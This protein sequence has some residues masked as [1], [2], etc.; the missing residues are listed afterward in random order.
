MIHNPVG[1]VKLD[2]GHDGG[3]RGR[4]G[5]IL[6]CLFLQNIQQAVHEVALAFEALDILRIF[7]T[8]LGS[9]QVEWLPAIQRDL[10]SQQGKRVQVKTAQVLDGDA[11][12][13]RSEFWRREDS[14]SR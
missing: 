9:Y 1:W 14:R 3:G 10:Q 5:D 12:G 8:L 13:N 7:K 6:D 4:V 2:A 11:G